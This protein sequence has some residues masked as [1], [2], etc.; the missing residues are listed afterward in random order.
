MYYCV[1]MSQETAFRLSTK[2]TTIEVVSY[3]PW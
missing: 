3:V 1:L 2:R